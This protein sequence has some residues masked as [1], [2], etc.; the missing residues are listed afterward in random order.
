MSDAL[1]DAQFAGTQ[2]IAQ[3]SSGRSQGG[4]GMGGLASQL[5]VGVN[6]SGKVQLQPAGT[7]Q[8]KL[9]E[10]YQGRQEGAQ[11]PRRAPTKPVKG[12]RTPRTPRQHTR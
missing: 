7:N 1:S 4:G 2:Q 6:D 11:T 3:Q 8:Y 9:Y 12:V 10:L 5:E